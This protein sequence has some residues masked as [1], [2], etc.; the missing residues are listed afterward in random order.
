MTVNPTPFVDSF[1]L[2]R[3][4]RPKNLV[5]A[6][7]CVCPPNMKMD[8]Y[9][10]QFKLPEPNSIVIKGTVRPFEKKDVSGVLKVLNKQAETK[11]IKIRHKL[12]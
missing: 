2:A 9:S 3:Y 10:R 1:T 11:D 5:D 4:L 6:C 12:S 7:Y 8:V